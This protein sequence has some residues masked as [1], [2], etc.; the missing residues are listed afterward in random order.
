M[1][2]LIL[3][4]LAQEAPPIVGGEPAQQ[5]AWPPVAAVLQDGRLHCTGVL[6]A[7][8]LVLTAG[9]CESERLDAVLLNRVDLD[10]EQGERVAIAEVL[11]HPDYRSSYDVA[12][13]VLERPAETAPALLALGCGASL[14]SDGA[15]AHILGY[16]ATNPAG[17]QV[18]EQLMQASLPVHDADCDNIGRGCRQDISPGGEL[19]AGGDGVDSCV[20][21][22]GGPL[23]LT[24]PRDV[25]YLA[26]LTSR[27][28]IP[29]NDNCGDGGI[30]TRLDAVAPWVEEQTGLTLELPDCQGLNTAPQPWV[31]ALALAPD[32]QALVQVDP[33][34]PDAGQEHSYT[35]LDAPALGELSLS[36]DGA[37]RYTAL[38]PGTE[39]LRIEVSDGLD[40]GVATLEV[41]VLALGDTGGEASAPRGCA[42]QSTGPAGTSPW[43]LLVLL[44]PWLATRRGLVRS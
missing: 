44:A 7:P 28:A 22:S 26:G 39:Q 18:A 30:Y 25:P 31:D 16:G 1:H 23:F 3:S 35:L 40:S 43:L 20:G 21:D 15:D 2:W 14:L 32:E 17:T 36:E 4:A 6:V 13:L 9:H 24:G 12:L 29:A 8:D 11:A 34:D 42:C 37:L 19:L 27:A 38:F 33:G 10:S 5:G 41:E